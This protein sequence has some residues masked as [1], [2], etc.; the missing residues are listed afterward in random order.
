M[1]L[2]IVMLAVLAAASFGAAVP[3]WAEEGAVSA[4]SRPASDATS[5]SEPNAQRGRKAFQRYCSVCHGPKG[6]GGV[7]PSLQG[8]STR[9]TPEQIEHQMVEPRGTMPR[10]YPSPIDKAVLGDLSAYLQLLK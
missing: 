1:K 9:L 10:M 8:I 7:G 2:R 5:A 4:A 3:G 6:E